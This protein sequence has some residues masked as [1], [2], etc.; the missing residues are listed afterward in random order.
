MVG[1]FARITQS[2]GQ[3]RDQVPDDFGVHKNIPP[4]EGLKFLISYGPFGAGD[5]ILPRV[6]G[7][8]LYLF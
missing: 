6:R 3:K 4:A 8:S 7:I 2:R 5:L 1:Y